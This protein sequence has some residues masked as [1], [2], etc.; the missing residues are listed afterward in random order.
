[1]GTVGWRMIRSGLD[2]ES[3]NTANDPSRGPT[4]IMLSIATSVDAL[5]V[6]LSL[7]MLDVPIFYPAVVI[8]I[9]T[10]II[11]MTGA[12]IGHRLDSAF[13]KRMEIIGGIVLILIG[14][15]ILMSHL[16]GV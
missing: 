2:R 14:L 7:G 5:A 13:G 4:L 10:F 16:T 8:G 3:E 15:R 6:G 12:Y 9:V 11:S 1:M